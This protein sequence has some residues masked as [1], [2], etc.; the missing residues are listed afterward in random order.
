MQGTLV[1]RPTVS[2]RTVA[3]LTVASPT[4]ARPGLWLGDTVA[5]PLSI[6]PF[7]LIHAQFTMP[8]FC[9]PL[10]LEVLKFL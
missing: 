9:F 3:R 10:E 5:G 4:V 7:S 1:A 2:R 8:S 6:C